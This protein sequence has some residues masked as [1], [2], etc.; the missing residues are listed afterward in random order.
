MAGNSALWRATGTTDG[1]EGVA[2]ASEKIEFNE[3]VVPNTTSHIKNSEDEFDREPATNEKAVGDIDELQD[4]GLHKVF[5]T[6]TGHIQTPS[7]TTVSTIIKKWMLESH[8][9]STTGFTKGKFGLRRDDNPINNL[10]P[11]T[12]ANP[13]GTRGYFITNFKLIR[14]PEFEGKLDFI[15]TLRLN[16]SI[17]STPYSW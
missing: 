5:V 6:I 12:D 2:A 14:P 17:G 16:G 15:A 10:T 1:S 4:I 11:T 3:G 13:T 9:D 7:S 8:A